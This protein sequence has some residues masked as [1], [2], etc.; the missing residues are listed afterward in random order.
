MQQKALIKKDRGRVLDCRLTLQL[1]CADFE[2]SVLMEEEGRGEHSEFITH[3]IAT[4]EGGKKKNETRMMEDTGGL[5]QHQQVM[6][7]MPEL[8]PRFFEGLD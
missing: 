7:T 1:V 6:S 8:L 3:N 5:R 2:E 4:G